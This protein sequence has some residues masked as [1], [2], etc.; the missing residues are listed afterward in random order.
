MKK[1]YQGALMIGLTTLVCGGVMLGQPTTMTAQT[2]NKCTPTTWKST[3]F[4]QSANIAAGKN[5]VEKL[6]NGNVHLFSKNN[7]G[8][9]TGDHDGIS[10]YYTK[11]PKTKNFDLTATVTVQHFGK[12]DVNGGTY[13]GQEGFGI[14]ARDVIGTTDNDD[15]IASNIVAV[16]GFV[17][18][19][20]ASGKSAFFERTGVT[21]M[22][23]EGSKGLKQ[24]VIDATSPTMPANNY[25][26]NVRLVKNNS[27]F[28]GG[29]VDRHGKWITG[30]ND[31][32]YTPDLL[33]VQTTD[34]TVGF[35]TA[36]NAEIV[37]K[38]VQLKTSNT[39]TDRPKVDDPH[40]VLPVEP[41]DKIAQ[42][43]MNT[44]TFVGDTI[45]VAPTA[46]GQGTGT[47]AQPVDI[48][49]ATACVNPGQTIVLQGGEYNLDQQ[50]YINYNVSGTA[51]KPVTLISAAQYTQ[52]NP[53]LVTFDNPGTLP[54]VLNLNQQTKSIV[55]DADYWIVS[56]VE[57]KN[58]LANT[59]GL[60]I[61]GSHNV[62]ENST[63][64][65]N[66]DSGL[67]VGLSDDVL[68]TTYWPHDNLVRYCASYLNED[69][70]HNN[71]D[72]FA[73]KLRSGANNHLDH[74]SAYR[75]IDDGYDLYNKV[76]IGKIGA[77]L[78]TNSLAHDNGWTD[79]IAITGDGN[80]FKLG[81]EGMSVNHVLRDSL[82]YGN[83]A[84]GVSSNS[85][86]IGTIQNVHAWNNHTNLS[87]YTFSYLQLN[88]TVENFFETAE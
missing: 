82:S 32:F 8:K 78:I 34:Y 58:S 20:G 46:T 77:V 45:Y 1:T 61:A 70:S 5:L 72:G 24:T 16:G 67:L 27:G 84:S 86:P 11:L 48:Y 31:F 56:G 88:W 59:V 28:K 4:G 22:I 21:S 38:N 33:S 10:Y 18:D 68:K 14:M 83:L 64:H 65:H 35:Y 40:P 13:D 54:V 41:K 75:N 7:G 30:R 53:N 52:S 49:T 80:G 19:K 51:T 63:F 55:L 43:R 26:Y 25:T 17:K 85:N 6:R 36:R 9:I 29:I 39:K 15:L 60:Q 71:A 79:N 37:V 57:I 66:G 2:I 3:V 23:G 87:L 47:A 42:P 50:L 73:V 44:R 81:G 62:V 69:P 12:E 74:V 76:G